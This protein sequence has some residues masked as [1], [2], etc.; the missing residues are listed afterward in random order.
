[1]PWP[2]VRLM[3][4]GFRPEVDAVQNRRASA[5]ACFTRH[6]LHLQRTLQGSASL[7]TPIAEHPPDA[8]APPPT[9]KIVHSGHHDV[10]ASMSAARRRARI[11]RQLTRKGVTRRMNAAHAMCRF[12]LPGCRI[13]SST[14]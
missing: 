7:G 11:N 1:V 3:V 5:M 12:T 9:F 14:K 6:P 10:T 4:T 8:G 13:T 2:P